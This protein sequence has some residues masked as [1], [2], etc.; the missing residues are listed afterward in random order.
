PQLSVDLSQARHQGKSC[1]G[2]VVQRQVAGICEVRVVLF[3]QI[4]LNS[5]FLNNIPISSQVILEAIYIFGASYLGDA[6]SF[7]NSAGAV[8]EIGS[9]ILSIIINPI[10]A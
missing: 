3:S 6:V 10:V 7:I 9:N 2:S 4:T 1:I 8:N 5:Y